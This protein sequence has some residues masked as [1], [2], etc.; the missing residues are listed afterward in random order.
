MSNQQWPPPGSQQ[1][2]PW[3]QQDP[4]W[5]PQQFHDAQGRD[6]RQPF[7]QSDH[8]QPSIE[9]LTPPRKSKGV[10]G[11]VIGVVVL[12]ATLLVGAQFFTGGPAEPAAPVSASADAQATPTESR[13]GNYIPFEGNGDGIFEIVDYQ[14]GEQELRLRIRVEIE[15]GEYGFAVFAFTNESRDSYDPVDPSS[16]IVRAGEPV[17][18]EVTFYM[19][20]ADSTIVLT[21]PSGRVALNALPVEAP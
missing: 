13:T 4:N 2:N 6:P 16:F 5:R 12:I 7:G 21:T 15:T 19:P 10:W 9:E 20:Q 17:E 1:N 11:I 14:W 18:R 8:R 3:A